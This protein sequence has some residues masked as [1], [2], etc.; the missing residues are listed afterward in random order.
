MHGSHCQLSV[1]GHS[2]LVI[3]EFGTVPRPRDICTNFYH[4]LEQTGIILPVISEINDSLGWVHYLEIQPPP[5]STQPCIP[6]GSLNQVPAS[7]GVK[8]GKSPLPDGR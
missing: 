5:R 6:P 3:P 1:A 8:A 2:A 4:S 7:A